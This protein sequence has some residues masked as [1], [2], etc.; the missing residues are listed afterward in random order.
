[1]AL[2]W[3][4]VKDK[5][6]ADKDKRATLLDFDRV[7]GLRLAPLSGVKDEIPKRIVRFVE[8]RQKAREK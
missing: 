1:L 7:L 5:T 2:I 4:L 3:K 8:R 6:V